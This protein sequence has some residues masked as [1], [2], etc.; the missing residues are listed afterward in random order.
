MSWSHQLFRS[1]FDGYTALLQR[2][3]VPNTLKDI[4]FYWTAQVCFLLVGLHWHTYYLL[5]VTHDEQLVLS[6]N[7][8]QVFSNLVSPWTSK[9]KHKATGDLQ[10]CGYRVFQWP[11]SNSKVKL[12]VHYSPVSVCR[13]LQNWIQ[14]LWTRDQAFARPTSDTFFYFEEK[15]HRNW[16]TYGPDVLNDF[17]FALVLHMGKERTPV[18]ST[19]WSY[20]RLLSVSDQVSLWIRRREATNPSGPI[21]DSFFTR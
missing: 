20:S 1:T 5:L 8:I 9:L 15:I 13:S 2:T 4:V 3:V 14:F 12:S 18:G 17:L 19:K 10:M 11:L 16:K 6:R 21:L 7:K